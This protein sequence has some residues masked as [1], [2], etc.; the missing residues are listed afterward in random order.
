MI[1]GEIPAE[2][3]NGDYMGFEAAH[4]FPQ[5]RL[6]EWTENGFQNLVTDASDARLISAS[7]IHSPQNGILL[8]AL[9]HQLFDNYR[10]SVDPDVSN[11]AV[12]QAF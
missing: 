8:S 5:A 12:R 10:L 1:S 6:Q 2:V 11:L 7:K 4:I 9:V 3:A